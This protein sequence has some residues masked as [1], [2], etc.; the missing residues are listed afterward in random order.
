MGDDGACNRPPGID[1]KIA[2]G[3]VQSFRS[4]NNQFSHALFVSLAVGQ[5]FWKV[6]KYGLLRAGC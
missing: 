2:S 6:R 3:A 4:G 5:S 1:I